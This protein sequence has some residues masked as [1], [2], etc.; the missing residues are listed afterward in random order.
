MIFDSCTETTE[1]INKIKIIRH[2]YPN[3]TRIYQFL[4]AL[5]ITVATN[6]LCF[7][8]LKL[9]KNKLRS[10]LMPD[11]MEWLIISSAEKDLLENADLS[12]FA[13]EWSH[14]KN[15]RVKLV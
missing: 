3:A 9:I 11:K 2:G 15:R 14:L 4:L 13:E 12:S 10:T 7:S 8:K 6:E 5:P 1:L